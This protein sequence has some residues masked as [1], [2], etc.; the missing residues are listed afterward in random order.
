[1]LGAARQPFREH[2]DLL[3]LCPVIELKKQPTRDI[4]KKRCS[5]NMQQ[6]YRRTTMPKWNRTSARVLP[7]KFAA[8]FQN[9]FFYEHLWVATSGNV[10]GLWHFVLLKCFSGRLDKNV[11][12]TRL[13]FWF[14]VATRFSYSIPVAYMA[15]VLLIFKIFNI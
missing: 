12:W 7:C 4:L 9:T 10:F 5:E 15:K 11:L 2:L 8:Y 6:I 14:P 1:M 13:L 3:L